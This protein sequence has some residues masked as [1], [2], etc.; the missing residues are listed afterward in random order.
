MQLTRSLTK[1][2]DKA[3][4]CIDNVSVNKTSK[5]KWNYWHFYLIFHKITCLTIC[6]IKERSLAVILITKL[7]DGRETYQKEKICEIYCY[8]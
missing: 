3:E 7:E 1:I 4:F 2:E 8:L 5:I 6:W